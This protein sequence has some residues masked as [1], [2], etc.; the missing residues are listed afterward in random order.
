[1]RPTRAAALALLCAADMLVAIDGMVVTVAL[2]AIQRD[3]GAAQ[4]DLQWVITAYT[5]SLGAF[6][7]VG[8]RAADLYGRRRMLVAGMTLFA[9]ASLVAG[10]APSL[11]ALLAARAVQ[12]LGAALAI[13]AALALISAIYRAER[14]RERA[15][16]M[17]AT[18]ITTGM[19]AG[20]VL[21]GALTAWLGWPWCFFVVVPFG[22]AAAA[23]APTVL[24]ES[25]DEAT[26]SI[27]V[28]GAVLAALGCG[29]LAFGFARA[30]HDFP[31]AAASCAAGVALLAVF[32]AVERRATAPL[33]RL[34]I[35]RHRPLTGANLAAIAHGGCFGGM[36]FLA[37]LSMQRTLGFS[38]LEAG[39]AFLPMVAAAT[40]GGHLGPRI[41]ARVG[42][43]RTAALG[44]AAS[45]AAYVLLART[46]GEGGYL[47]ILLPAFIVA[48]FA[49]AA[50]FVALTT[51]GI[52]GVREGEKGLA[53]GL[54]QTS[55][56]LGGA[57]VLA[58]LAGIAAARG[59]S[60]AFLCAAA[61]M[62]LSALSALRTLPSRTDF[63]ARPII[64]S[65]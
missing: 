29:L 30:E 56:H 15:V 58:L 8:G 6:L 61:L 27:D 11:P 41:I 7:L 50:A 23:L 37:T 19:G 48:G 43:R 5:L 12:G 55:M 62:L 31:A 34:G 14:E 24:D 45:A 47:T 1:M 49:L 53:S 16:G 9:L 60:A 38:A 36:M 51:Q 21:G 13:P 42:A 52:S 44:H 64:P 2:P 26:G 46:P 20:L 25:R 63:A 22:L 65:G 17:L 35:L 40:L 4:S 28:A 18:A 54:F 33:V 32:V 3:L 10:L 39:L 59:P 57:L